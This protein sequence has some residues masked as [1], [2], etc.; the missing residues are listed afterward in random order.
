MIKLI[1]SYP[2]DNSYNYSKSF[3]TKA[4]QTAYFNTF[5]SIIENEYDDDNEQGYIKE[6]ESF[7]VNYNYDDLV[8]EGVNYVLFDNGYKDIFAFIVSKEYLS[9][10]VTR[11]NYE[12]DVIQTYMFDFSLKKSF[13]ERKV[14][15]LNEVSDFDEGLNLGEHAIVNITNVFDKDAVYFAM[16]NGFKEQQLMFNGTTLASVVDL[17]FKTGK[18]LTVIDGIQYPLYFMPLQEEYAIA[19]FSRI[20][21]TG[22]GETAGGVI[23]AKIFRFIKGFEGFAEYGA[24]FNGESFKTAGYGTT[25]IYQGN[26]YSQLEPFPCTEAEASIV[27]AS[28]MNN[29]FAEPLYIRMLH[30][31]LRADQIKQH[32]FD[33]F[34]S[35]AMNGGMGAVTSSPMYTK[36]LVN[37]EDATIY[38]SWLT[39]YTTAGGVPMAGLVSRRAQ[40]AKIFRDNIYEYR[41][42]SQYTAGGS[43]A[44][45]LT[46]NNGNGFIPTTVNGV[47]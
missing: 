21:T 37:Q 40:E 13:V 11:L 2:Y 43:P 19:S 39:W 25:E 31:G 47:L 27:L 12:I 36:Y 6:G 41:A 15:T 33:A 8:N 3:T 16:F 14:C 10:D 9:E 35:L 29:A 4:L 44:G 45:T 34:V 42:I 20:N 18:P 26:Y 1:K 38:D 28:M 22:T 23:S 46:D 30:D 17:P 7:S 5:A 32:H 24:Y